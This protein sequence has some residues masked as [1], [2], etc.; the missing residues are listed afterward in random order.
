ML[1]FWK[2]G[3]R[4]TDLQT[5]Q[6]NL[7]ALDGSMTERAELLSASCRA[8]LGL[9]DVIAD[10]CVHAE[11]AVL[12][13]SDTELARICDKT[14]KEYVDACHGAFRILNELHIE[15]DFVNERLFREKRGRYKVLIA[16]ETIFLNGKFAEELKRFVADGGTLITDYRFA[17]KREDSFQFQTMPGFGL[18]EAAGISI[19][20]F[21]YAER[22]EVFAV[23]DYPA[24]PLKDLFRAQ[25]RLNG[26]SSLADYV[27]GGC[28]LSVHGYG[29]GKYVCWGFSPFQIF[30]K[31]KTTE[32]LAAIREFFRRFCAEAGVVPDVKIAGDDAFQ[33]QTGVLCRNDDPASDKVCFLINFSDRGLDCRVELP[34][35]TS[36]REVLS[37]KAIDARELDLSFGAYETKIFDCRV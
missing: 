34:A 6:Y 21:T 10:S 27:H 31:A 24:V 19:N 30:R 18:Q 32:K 35:F 22:D 14:Y 1:M 25:L 3:G 26:A 37:G 28:A 23:T 5:D 16:P 33:M 9:K 20:D 7:M 11:A 8:F 13:A 4:V 29:K 17:Q 2:F 36:C 15:C 12:L